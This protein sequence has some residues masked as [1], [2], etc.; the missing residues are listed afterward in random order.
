[1]TQI[2]SAGPSDS[3]A[4]GGE[5]MRA[6]WF[7][8]GALSLI[9]MVSYLDRQILTLLFT[10]IKRDFNLTDTEVSLL[11]GMA[12]VVF[13]IVFGLLFGRLADHGNRRRII[14][15][16]ALCWSIA[17]AACGLTR[18]FVQLF[19]AR[20]CV[21]IGEATLN[22]SALS[23]MA[24]LFP[25]DRLAKPISVYISAQY[26]GVGLAL[27]IGGLAIQLV[28]QLPP[29]SFPGQP[30]LRDWQLTF[31]I[32]GIGGLLLVSPLLFCREPARRGVSQA[33][34][35]DASR[36]ELLG[37][38]AS[39]RA[40]L[41]SHFIGF[42]LYSMLGF[43]IAA[44]VP[45]FFMRVHGWA[46]Q[47]I[48]YVYGFVIAATGLA[49]ALSGAQLADWLQRR[50]VKDVY[51]AMPIGT[52]LFGGLLAIG[53][54]ATNPFVAI[55]FLAAQNVVATLSASLISASLQA[56]APNR[57]R[58]QLAS[59]YVAFGTLLGVAGGPTVVALVTDNLYRNEQAVGLSIVTAAAVITPIVML[60]LH[61]GRRPLLASLE[62]AEKTG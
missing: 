36:T 5:A 30:P 50:G 26:L 31:I 51:F 62:R 38:L 49:G 57:L 28:A 46:A 9:N 43:G 15:I 6:A 35:A 61:L 54:L 58:G 29:I 48:G 23:M 55:A 11:A 14:L 41:A 12:F 17:T 7:T 25:R 34:K 33:P 4:P 2:S 32:V 44:W 22:P 42:G 37:F 10:P 59:I 27:V 13:F 56:I 16:G 39:N 40:T 53:L 1:M 20:I 60:V 19:V 47:D 18:N 52:A 45:T 3:V 8:V 21:G 24:D